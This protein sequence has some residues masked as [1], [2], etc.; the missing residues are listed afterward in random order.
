MRIQ[1]KTKLTIGGS[2]NSVRTTVPVSVAQALDVKV[3]DKINWVVE[4]ESDEVIVYVKK[5]PSEK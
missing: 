4:T 5:V 1:Q 3:G 2:S